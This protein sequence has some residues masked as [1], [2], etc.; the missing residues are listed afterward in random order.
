MIRPTAD[1][2]LLVFLPEPRETE[3]GIV[4]PDRKARG[5]ETRRARVV[6]VGPGHHERVNLREARATHGLADARYKFVPTEVKP[7]EVVLVD[8]KA[9]QD[10]TLDLDVPRHNKGGDFADGENEF[11]LVREAE[12]LGVLE[13]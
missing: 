10:Y 5:N 3:S 4:L 9:G 6:A 2:V 8:C 11:R 12:I 13:P 1:N 7:G